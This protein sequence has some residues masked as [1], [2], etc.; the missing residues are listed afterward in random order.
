LFG[1]AAL[2]LHLASVVIHLVNTLI[3]FLFARD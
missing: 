1:C 2:P 3:L